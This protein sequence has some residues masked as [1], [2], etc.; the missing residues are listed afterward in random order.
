MTWKTIL[1]P[2]YMREKNK[3]NQF[4]DMKKPV[5]SDLIILIIYIS[6]QKIDEKRSYEI[7]KIASANLVQENFCFS[8]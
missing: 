8:V 5:V 2:T 7:R 6:C 3:Q 1:S 4:Y